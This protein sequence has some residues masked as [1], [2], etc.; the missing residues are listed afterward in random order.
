[1]SAP[2]IAQ[3]ND[4]A[5]DEVTVTGIRQSIKSSIDAKRVASSIVE[6]VSAEDIGKL[7]DV[8]IAEAISRMPGLASQEPAAGLRLFHSR[9]GGLHNRPVERARASNRK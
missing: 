9:L 5:V 8:S 1:M 4:E 7:P 2:A 6:A 3:S